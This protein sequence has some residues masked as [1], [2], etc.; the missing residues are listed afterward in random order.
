MKKIFL[1]IIYSCISITVIY[2]VL[3]SNS[4]KTISEVE[5][6]T[7]VNKNDLINNVNFKNNSF[8][9]TFHNLTS[10]QYPLKKEINY[11][12]NIYNNFKCIVTNNIVPNNDNVLIKDGQGY[13][14]SNTDYYVF[15]KF[16]YDEQKETLLENRIWNFE[17]IYEKYGDMYK[18]YIY[19]PSCAYEENWFDNRYYTSQANYCWDK[20]YNQ[21][22]EKY[23]IFKQNYNDLNDYKNNHYK[24]D[25]HWNYK[26]AYEGYCE[27]IDII[28]NDFKEINEPYKIASTVQSIYPFYGSITSRNG[29]V[30]GFD[31]FVAYTLDYDN[32]YDY[33]INDQKVESLGEGKNALLR[34]DDYYYS[35]YYG[36]SENIKIVN[37]NSNNDLS[38]LIFGD[39]FTNSIREDLAAH[40]KYTYIIDT[41]GITDPSDIYNTTFSLDKF[42]KNNKIDCILWLQYFQNLY[43]ESS[44]Y[45]HIDLDY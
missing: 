5:N 41:R 6:R 13:K 16:N 7:L 31:E 30:L 20:I 19:K 15:D 37:N 34:E 45:L 14:I 39:S 42:L 26:G 28:R 12:G 32:N 43:F 23:T 44:C 36:T 29:N 35:S 18:M 24:T 25:H 22:N 11:L 21:L 9:N 2:S 8:Q 27:I 33:Y 40:F 38:I 3:I 10:D 17:R 4:Q 1:L